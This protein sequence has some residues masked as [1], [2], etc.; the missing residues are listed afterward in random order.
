MKRHEIEKEYC[1]LIDL[2]LKNKNRLPF[3]IRDL[4]DFCQ[5]RGHQLDFSEFY[6][7][8]IKQISAEKV[9]VEY[10]TKKWPNNFYTRYMPDKYMRE[11]VEF[12][13]SIN[14]STKETKVFPDPGFKK[15]FQDGFKQ[16][17]LN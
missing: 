10:S 2:F 3:S 7:L 16:E 14:E 6:F 4:E 17:F 11:S 13:C 1:Y 9:Q 5:S 15:I 8:E 12:I